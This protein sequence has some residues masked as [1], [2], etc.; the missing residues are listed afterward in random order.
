MADKENAAQ[1]A[2]EELLTDPGAPDKG[3]T[4]PPQTTDAEPSRP[5][6]DAR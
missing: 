3:N 2:T 1:E 6:K 4:A 5:D